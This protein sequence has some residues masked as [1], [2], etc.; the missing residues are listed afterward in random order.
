MG[1]KTATRLF[2]LSTIL[3]VSSCVENPI[4]IDRKPVESDAKTDDGTSGGTTT[5]GV[6]SSLCF[7]GITSLTHTDSTV[8]LNWTAHANAIAYDVY[9]IVAGLPVLKLTVVGQA[10]NTTTISG[11]TPGNTYSYRI[12]LRTN[13]GTSDANTN[14]QSATLD[15]Q[16]SGPS[17][18]TR[19]APGAASSSASTATIRVA[20]IK[21]GEIV[22]L[23]SDSSCT[24]EVATGTAT[25]SS[26]DLVSSNLPLGLATFAVQIENSLGNLST[27]STA[28]ATATFTRTCPQTFGDFLQVPADNAVGVSADFCV[29]KYEARFYNNKP[30][31]G[32]AGAA[33]NYISQVN[34][35]TAC[36]ALGSGYGLISNPEWQA[37][38]RNIEDQNSNWLNG[39]KGTDYLNRGWSASN[40]SD[41]FDNNTTAPSSA[42]N[43]LYNTG[44]NTCAGAGSFVHK[45]THRLSTGEDIW[46][47]SGNVEEWVDWSVTC[48]GTSCDKAYKF[49][50]TVD[51]WRDYSE[52][53]TKISSSDV[54]NINTAFS[55]HSTYNYGNNV[56][57]YNPG[58]LT[59][60]EAVMRGGAWYN[61][62]V[63][64]IFNLSFYDPSL[65]YEQFGFRCTYKP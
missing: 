62:G 56:G 4:K 55:A 40:W 35:R 18:L 13:V 21:S 60:R 30:F 14:N 39:V 27:C 11:L 36:A 43:C 31:S 59:D 16:S 29:M 52:L 8:T 5:N 28:T 25:S 20:G 53:D 10:S 47:I 15:T 41:G 6:D 26:I 44:A 42:A 24:D 49:G 48:N 57:S 46:D 38:A 32:S 50:D 1:I 23:F 34:A 51:Y 7:A 9:D 2:F 33:W 3:L 37:V 61:G 58:S 12:R 45:R 17:S 63:G 54:I 22:H 19:I 64:G 65:A